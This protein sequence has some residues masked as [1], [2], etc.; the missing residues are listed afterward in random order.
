V[1]ETFNVCLLQEDSSHIEY[2]EAVFWD[3]IQCGSDYKYIYM[4][5]YWPKPEWQKMKNNVLQ[6]KNK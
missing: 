2:K 5:D 3:M 4:N 1:E 6:R